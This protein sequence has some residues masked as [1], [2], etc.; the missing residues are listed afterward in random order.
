MKKIFCILALL[1]PAVSQAVELSATTK[2]EIAHLFSYLENSGC[3][4]NRNGTWYAPTE[5]AAH[6]QKKYDYLLEK[7]LLTT[8]ESFIDKAA[9]ESSMSGKPYA[10]KCA[11][12]A[13]VPS[14]IWFNAELQKYRKAK[15][16]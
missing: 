3:Q 7:D 13:A 1:M 4:F 6:I 5:A 16:K 15:N 12:Q 2:T 9:T 14:A 10:V 8:A 11:G